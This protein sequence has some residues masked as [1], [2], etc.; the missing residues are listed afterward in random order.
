[1]T[2]PHDSWAEVYDLAYEEEFGPFYRRLTDH[3][4]QE[5]KALVDLPASIV[6]FGAGT[7]RL[8]VPLSQ[9]GYQVTAV[10]PCGSML[11]Q[12]AGHGEG[13]G[14]HRVHS[15][16]EDFQSAQAFDLAICVF[17][18]IIYLLDKKQL[19][20]ALTSAEACLRPG[21]KLLLD[22]PSPALFRSRT[23]RTQTL[24]RKVAI[25]PLGEGL[26]SY[27]EE[28][29]LHG[30]QPRVFKDRFKIR[31]WELEEVFEA[32]AECEF[33]VHEDLTDRFHG[34]GSHYLVFIAKK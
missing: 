12:L 7:G 22:V 4:V 34:T 2:L 19:R 11:E 26:H 18:V 25:R 28:I 32:A 33:E 14:I 20:R 6:D 24:E 21:G 15:S 16:M 17:T 27:S 8:S 23:T 10:E 30:E 9:A 3:T 29:R 5:I 1:M 13:S 31:C